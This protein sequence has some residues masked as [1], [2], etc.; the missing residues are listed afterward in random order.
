MF[1][2]SK[3]IERRQKL[4]SLVKQGLI[5]LLGNKEVSLNY[6]ANTY[7]F[8]QDSSFLYFIGINIPNIAAIID[9]E[10]NETILYGD[11]IDIEDVIWMGHLPSMEELASQAGITKVKPYKLLANDLSN[12]LKNNRKIHYTP[13]YRNANKIFLSEVLQIPLNQIKEKS[14]P[15]LC[16][17][18]ALLRSVKDADEIAH[19]DEIM[20]Y[21][22]E[23]HVTAMQM[24][25]EGMHEQKIAGAIEGIAL[26]Y[27]ARVSFPVILSKHGEILHNHH[28]NNILHK[29][30][31][32]LCD[33]GFESNLGYATDH[34]RT[35]PVGGKFLQQQREIYEI[36]L[37]ANNKVI[38][39][40][41]PGVYYRDIHIAAAKEITEGLKAL[42]LMK[43][44]TDEA[45][46]AGAHALFFPHGL[47]H[48]MG[49]DVHDMED[50]GE[51][52][53]GYD[54][55]IER[56][57]QFGLAYLRLAKKLQTGFVIT[58]EPGIYFIPALIDLWKS[59][60]KF[61]AFIN[62]EKVETYKGFGGIRLEDD[63]LITETGCRLLGKKRIP[64]AP[65]EVEQTVNGICISK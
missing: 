41:K 48:M 19:L 8:R 16:K 1:E 62:Y 7:A 38:S 50:I 65:E 39:L 6:P 18:I 3:Y 20:A 54:E 47:G 13:P 44:N 17:A 4:I 24:A 35:I 28:H 29:G 11:N 26:Q 56:S 33:A 32:L 42:G 34:T 59:E 2:K 45:V 22:Y 25:Q 60:R 57:Q 63:L 23:M 61:E 43:G 53:V 36:V 10:Q 58:D 9:V 40:C 12:A 31:L 51:A 15:E 14:S 52:Y 46:E 64:I 37:K 21:G 5:V 30:D 49:L 27:G 55:T